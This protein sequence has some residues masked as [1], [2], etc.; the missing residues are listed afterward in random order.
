MAYLSNPDIVVALICGWC[1]GSPMGAVL[2][3]WSVWH[4]RKTARERE[5]RRIIEEIWN[6]MGI[7][8]KE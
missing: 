3:L 1:I 4:D 6:E 7:I 8:W 5:K 2:I